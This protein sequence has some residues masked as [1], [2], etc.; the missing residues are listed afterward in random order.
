MVNAAK[1]TTQIFKFH[2]K[3]CILFNFCSILM[4][5]SLKFTYTVRLQFVLTNYSKL[6]PA[7]T[8]IYYFRSGLVWT[9]FGWFF[10]VLVPVLGFWGILGPDRF[11][12]HRK[13]AKEPGPDRTFK[14]Y[15]S[16]SSSPLWVSTLHCPTDSWSH[17]EVT[18]RSLQESTRLRQT[19]GTKWRQVQG[20][21][22]EPIDLEL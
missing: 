10:S 2:E 13:T 16:S 4:I 22:P 15:S 21:N 19:P 9:G 12:V 5:K 8:G 1:V 14:H 18:S 11:S 17:K 7:L 3:C 20:L 6:L